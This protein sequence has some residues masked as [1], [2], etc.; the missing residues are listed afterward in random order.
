MVDRLA[1]ELGP[2]QPPFLIKHLAAGAEWGS[3]ALAARRAFVHP[4]GAPV[5]LLGL[6]LGV[7]DPLDL[8]AQCARQVGLEFTAVGETGQGGAAAAIGPHTVVLTATGTASQV[9]CLLV[10]R[11]PIPAATASRASPSSS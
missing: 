10:A 7:A 9:R 8:A 2:D 3:E 6:E 5:R 11:G 4:V 1:T